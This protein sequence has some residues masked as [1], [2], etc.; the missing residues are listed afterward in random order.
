MTSV[1]IALLGATGFTGGLTAD[2]LST[3]LPSGASWAIAGRNQAK[4]EAVADRIETLGG[5]RPEIISASTD[6]ADSMAALAGSTRVLITTVGPYVQLGEPAVKAAAEAGIAYVDLTGEPEFVDAMWLK[7]HE[8]ARRTGARLIHACGFDSIPYDLGVLF[9]VEQMPEGVPLDVKGY[10][11]AGGTASGGTYH[12]AVGAF[13]RLRQSARTAAERKK[14]EGRPDDRRVRG[15][16]S[17]GR[18][19]A[20][21]G[22]ALPLP[23]IDPQI[24]LRSARSLDRY[25]PDFT[26]SHFA[27]FKKLPMLAGTIAGGA[28]LMAGAQLRPTRSLLLKLKAQGDGPDEQKR[29][30]SWFSLRIIATGGGTAVTTEVAGGDPGYTET[31]KMLS[32]SALCLAF[33]DALPEVSGQTTTAVAMGDALITRLQAAGITFRTL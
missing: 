19:A 31:A 23:T 20:G 2:Y 24:V 11:R 12:S 1:D 33:D 10:I 16:G 6:N 29:A 15:G 14:L 3:H 13:A 7:Y 18:G 17:I 27:Q 25:G 4:L 32:E 5:V 22:W 28:V 26:Y 30:K 8:T 9:T 21:R